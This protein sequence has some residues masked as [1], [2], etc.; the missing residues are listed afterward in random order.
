MV[1]K[2]VFMEIIAL[3]HQ[4]CSIRK[5][6]ETLGIPRNTGKCHLESVAFPQCHKSRHRASILA[7]HLQ[8]IRDFLE[9]DDYQAPWICNRIKM[10]GYL[11]GYDPVKRYVQI[12]KEQKRGEQNGEI[13][14]GVGSS[15]CGIG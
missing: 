8:T 2:G 9:D 15:A 5:I 13:A 14:V 6:A 4:G 1:S 7:P 11:G 10:L 3:R 12:M